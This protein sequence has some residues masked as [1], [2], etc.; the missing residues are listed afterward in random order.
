[1]LAYTMKEAVEWRAMR[2]NAQMLAMEMAAKNVA[3]FTDIWL[4]FWKQPE[5]AK[6]ITQKIEELA[7]VRLGDEGTY[8]RVLRASDSRT[9]QEL[10]GDFNPV[11]HDE[12]FARRTLIKLTCAL[13]KH[14]EGYISAA[15]GNKFKGCL[16][17]EEYYKCLRPVR[18]GEKVD[19]KV[20]VVELI[21]SRNPRAKLDCTAH[22]GDELAVRGYMVILLP[23]LR[24]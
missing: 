3:T 22:V 16:I 15:A 6:A 19:A 2:H 4:S 18:F 7:G 17:D 9:M 20:K 23:N 11:H 14:V 5:E 8:S 13:A 24:Q 21:P 12:D 1:M 10:T